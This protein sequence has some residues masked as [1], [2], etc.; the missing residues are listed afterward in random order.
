MSS[1]HAKD[2]FI[3]STKLRDI[4]DTN[5]PDQEKILR[6]LNEYDLEATSLHEIKYTRFNVR[7]PEKP[8]IKLITPK[9]TVVLEKIANH[10]LGAR[11][12]VATIK[13]LEQAGFAIPKLWSRRNARGDDI[14]RYILQVRDQFFVVESFVLGKEIDRLKATPENFWSIGCTLAKM[15]GVLGVQSKKTLGAPIFT[16]AL[17][18]N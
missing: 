3:G 7:F 5:I 14:D 11:F 1:R 12:I 16:Q 18:Q 9:R 2:V 6:V 17:P 15:H 10:L 13:K 4:L 8:P